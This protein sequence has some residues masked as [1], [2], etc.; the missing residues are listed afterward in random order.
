MK[1][2]F[3]K[4]HRWLGLL[5]AIQIIAWMSSGLYF[6]IFPIET[7]RGEHLT[8]EPDKLSLTMLEDLIGPNTA[9]LAFSAAFENESTLQEIRLVSNLGQVWYRITVSSDGE[10]QSRLVNGLSGTVL[11]FLQQDDIREIALG[12]LNEPGIIES[13][14]LVTEAG[15]WSEIRGRQLPLWRV[16]FNEPESLNL[17]FDGWT[18]ELVTRR[19]TRWRIF[20][21]LWMLHI[22]DFE[23]RDDFNTPLLQIAAA[24]GLLV[25]LSGLIFWAMTTSLFRRR[26]TSE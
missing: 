10:T 8:N 23:E 1:V 26:R 4:I 5:M 15:S 19:T 24:L 25:A 2:F 3:R 18:G 16:S 22:M 9:W 17:Y 11:E 7:I 6:A 12:R 20:D 13:I 21:F 14:D